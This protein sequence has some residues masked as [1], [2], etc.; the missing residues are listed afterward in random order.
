[1]ELQVKLAIQ[2]PWGPQV[3]KVNEVIQ[4]QQASKV[5]KVLKVIPEKRG[6]LVILV[7]RAIPAIQV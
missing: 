6:H 3:N 5:M 7:N 2:D 1:M 4:V